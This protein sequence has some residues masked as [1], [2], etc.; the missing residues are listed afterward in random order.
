MEEPLPKQ[1]ENKS[2]FPF[3]V[4]SPIGDG[5]YDWAKDEIDNPVC[6]IG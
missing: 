5:E 4:V 6:F 1:L 2:D 3:I